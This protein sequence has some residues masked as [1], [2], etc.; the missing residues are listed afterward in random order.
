MT[1]AGRRLRSF[2]SLA[3]AVSL[4]A[5]LAAVVAP[6]AADAQQVVPCDFGRQGDYESGYAKTSRKGPYEIRKPYVVE[7]ESKLDGATIQIGLIR[8]KIPDAHKVPVI[9]KASP[10]FHPLQTIDMRACAPELTENFVPHGY[11]VAFVAIRGTGD[12][13]GC[14]N[15]FGPAERADVDQAV[16]WLGTRPWSSGAV[17]MTGR[18]YPGSTPWQVASFGNPHLKTIVPISGVTDIFELMFGSGT[19]DWRGPLILNSLF[20]LQSGAFYLPGRSPQHTA[21]VLA[22][23]EYA[24]GNAASIHSSLTGE[25]DPLGYWE[26]RRY[27][28]EIERKYKGS[29]LLVQGLQDWNVN[30]A[31]Q[32][33]WVNKLDRSGLQV[34]YLLGQWGHTDPDDADGMAER[35][36]W[37]DI[38]L[39][40]FD[41]WLKGKEVDLGPRVQVQDSQGK[42]RNEAAWPPRGAKTTLFLDPDMTLSQTPGKDKGSATVG[43]DPAHTQEPISAQRSGDSPG[44]QLAG[45]VCEQPVCAQFST[46]VFREDF[47][48][49]G[50]PRMELSLVPRGPGGQLS[51]YLYASNEE[52]WKRLGWGQ[53]DLRFPTGGHKARPVIP[54]EEIK[55]DFALQPLDVVVPSGSRLV[56]VISGGT[57]YNRL[58]PLPNYPVE[59][60]LGERTSALSVTE[61]R[62]SADTF[63]VPPRGPQ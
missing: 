55:A 35:R 50:L 56:A 59:I 24:I 9:V 23:P 51:I 39:D 32:F 62:P 11:A 14:M 63:F 8:P 60:Q 61:V 17:G 30:P 53:V 4:V 38:L 49:A 27:R 57:S 34:K 41:R 45:D 16:T 43:P 58:N 54:G 46:G 25:L 22:C 42:W 21:E 36:D 52:E 6:H 15:Y 12:S 26:E 29:V 44:P 7:V 48:F 19:P 1:T 3:M 2:V 5:A 10:Y 31:Q 40:W 13:G 28:K 20:Y 33:P 37:P 18:S 47:R